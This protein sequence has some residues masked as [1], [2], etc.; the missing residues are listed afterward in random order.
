MYL[1]P[2]RTRTFV[3]P[4]MRLNGTKLAVFGGLLLILNMADAFYTL[5]YIH[6][7]VATEANPIMDALLRHGPM[8]FVLGKHFLVSLCVVVLWRMRQHR[9]AA[10]GLATAL[11]L[12]SLLVFY[13]VSMKI[14]LG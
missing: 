3:L 7:G 2:N 5:L 12:Y 14:A 11:P 13:H 6:S 9:L 8:A 10:F 1:E 4:M